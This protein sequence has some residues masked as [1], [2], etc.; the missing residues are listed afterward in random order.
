MEILKYNNISIKSHIETDMLLA[1]ISFDGEKCM[2]GTSDDCFE[3]HIL[4]ANFGIN[5]VDID[6]YFRIVFDKE[7]ADWTFVCPPNYKGIQD[8]RRRIKAFYKDGLVAIGDFLQQ[9]GLYVSIQIPPRY[10]RHLKYM[11]E[12]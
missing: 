9:I 6:K 12:E 2:V 1:V 8:K 10:N 5:S 3:H 11:L 7:G 4:L